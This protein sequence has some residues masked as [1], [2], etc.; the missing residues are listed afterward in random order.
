MNFLEAIEANKTKRI[1]RGPAH[2][3]WLVGEF[4]NLE[5][6]NKSHTEGTWEAEIFP[7]VLEFE[8]RW[9][10]R[11]FWVESIPVDVIF[12]ENIKDIHKIL[13]EL[14]GK[15]WRVRCEEIG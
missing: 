4:S 9:E 2:G 12:P 11:E 5:S 6:Y 8:C 7:Q 14:L 1:R 10:R 15:K 3:W 13:P